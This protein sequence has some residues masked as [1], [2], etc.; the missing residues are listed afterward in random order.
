MGEIGSPDQTVV[1]YTP[2]S[3]QNSQAPKTWIE[4]TPDVCGGDARVRRTRIPVWLLVEYR[5]A[6]LT[7]SKLLEAYPSLTAADLTCAWE[8]Y[9]RNKKEIDEAINRQEKA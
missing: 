3:E 1:V 6:G 4:K 7:D 2:K 9:D 5:Q 8:Y